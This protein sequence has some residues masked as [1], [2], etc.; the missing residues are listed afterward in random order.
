M[1]A[2]SFRYYMADLIIGRPLPPIARIACTCKPYRSVSYLRD[3]LPIVGLLLLLVPVNAPAQRLPIVQPTTTESI[4]FARYIGWLHARDLST[5]SGPVALAVG[6]SL[7]GLNKQGSLLAIHEVGQSE[8]SQYEILELQ[9]DSIVFERVIAPYFIVQRQVEDLPLSSVIITPRNYKFRYAGAVKS[10]ECSVHISD[11]T[12]E[13]SCGPDSRG[14]L[15]RAGDRCPSSGD[16]V[17][18]EDAF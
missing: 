9:G 17:L 15:D 8:R 4:A 2:Q 16:G 5:E 13:Q 10:R 14:A 11:C 12:E 1:K 6:A 3:V 7:P 18:S